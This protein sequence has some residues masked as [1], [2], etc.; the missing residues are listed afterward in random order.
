MKRA[1]CTKCPRKYWAQTTKALG[2]T[3]L[4]KGTVD[5][6][7]AVGHSAQVPSH[8]KTNVYLKHRKG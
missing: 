7:R 5:E 4:Y 2:V 1:Q 3:T 6:R 8:P